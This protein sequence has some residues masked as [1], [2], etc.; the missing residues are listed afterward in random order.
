M[1][2]INHN[3]SF[4]AV[5]AMNLTSVGQY[6]ANPK[7]LMKYFMGVKQILENIINFDHS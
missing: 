3:K 7:I 1:F 6:A 2:T 4:I 5:W